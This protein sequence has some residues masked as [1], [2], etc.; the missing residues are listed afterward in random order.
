VP[1]LSSS[2]SISRLR[3]YFDGQVIAPGDSAYDEARTVFMGGFDGRPAVIIRPS[4]AQTVARVIALAR[5]TGLPFAVRSGGHSGA[6]HSTVD[7]GLVL[8]LRGLRTLEIA[9]DR[10]SAWAGS[11]LTAGEYTRA[12][13]EHGLA[14]GFGDTG[15]VGLGG[16]TLSGGIGYLTRKYGMTVDNV[17]GAELVTAAG[18]VLDVSADSH[19]DLFWAIRGGGG[20]FGI[21]TRFRYRLHPV[22]S[23]VGGLLVLPATADVVRGVIDAA[24]SA[25]D[26]LSVIATVVPAPP[27]PFLP[28]QDHGR[29]VVMLLVCYAGDA[30]DG[31]RTI[32]PFRRLAEP[33]VDMIRPMRYP[34]IF[35]PDDPSYHPKAVAR[36]MFVDRVDTHAA[37]TI[38]EALGRSDAPMRAV[39]LRALGGAM[40]RVPAEATAFAH[41][42]SR[43]LVSIAAFYGG[44]DDK[45][46]RERWVA[47]VADALD[48]GDTGA[49]VGFLGD[50]GEA[51][52]RAAYPG[53]TGARLRAIKRRYDPDNLF[54]R[55][56]NIVPDGG[57]TQ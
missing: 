24:E 15:S 56:Q 14:T 51:R 34:E 31:P 54:R 13:G 20:N 7:G 44:P 19:P 36:T 57:A 49:Y 50:E 41:R 12:V 55:N 32:A 40:S 52:V 4:D 48:Q 21:V 1:Q 53:A 25:S 28:A 38:V 23:I 17:L 11:G 42:N 30:G 45:P 18:E 8:D 6:G 47:D 9:R 29:L 46:R 43:V 27:L 3:A 39:Q 5:E 37:Q 33:I 16:I 10:R 35:P 26:D 2:F 22:E